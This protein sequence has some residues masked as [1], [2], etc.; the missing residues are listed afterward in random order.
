MQRCLNDTLTEAGIWRMLIHRHILPFFGVLFK[1]DEVF[2]VSPLVK[3]GSLPDYLV[4]Y[5]QTDRP[6]LVRYP[7]AA[8]FL[9]DQIYHSYGTWQVALH[10]CTTKGFSMGMSK[11]KISW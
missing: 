2:L 10:S 5:P 4:A 9:F 7:N 1:K 8:I 3:N 11:G 6:T